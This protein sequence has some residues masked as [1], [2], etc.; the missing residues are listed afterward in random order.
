ML[1]GQKQ[2]ML[3][4][5]RVCVCSWDVGRVMNNSEGKCG[6][7]IYSCVYWITEILHQKF[8]YGN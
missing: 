6:S 1:D 8:V 4:W 7:V 5:G 3:E 2:V